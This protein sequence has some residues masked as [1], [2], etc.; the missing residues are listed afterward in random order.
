[1][2]TVEYTGA[3]LGDANVG[4]R[5]PRIAAAATGAV[6]LLAMDGG[7]YITHSVFGALRSGPDAEKAA[8]IERSRQTEPYDQLYRELKV[9]AGDSG[10]LRKSEETGCE[11]RKR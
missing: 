1:M 4:K 9:R 7:C 5:R 2:S 11:N 10:L 8:I 6:M 3:R